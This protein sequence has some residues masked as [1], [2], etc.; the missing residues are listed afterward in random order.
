VSERAPLNTEREGERE[1]HST[2]RERGRERA[3][4]NTER[5]RERDREGEREHH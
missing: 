3:P 1:H 4:L 2:Q 5:Q